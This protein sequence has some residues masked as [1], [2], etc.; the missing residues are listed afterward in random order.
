MTPASLR[1]AVPV[2]VVQRLRDA[3]ARAAFP[4]PPPDPPSHDQI[5]EARAHRRYVAASPHILAVGGRID[6]VRVPR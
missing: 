1:A 6:I 4:P 5:K 3:L 2:R